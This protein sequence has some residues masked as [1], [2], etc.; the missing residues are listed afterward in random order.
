[1]N[2]EIIDM[3][4]L[5]TKKVLAV[6]LEE[7]GK[8][9]AMG[10]DGTDTSYIDKVA[11]DAILEFMD[12]ND[13]QANLLSEEAGFVDR[14]FDEVLVIDPVD[15]TYN[16]VRGIP[17]FSISIARGKKMLSDLTEGLVLNMVSGDVYH[18][19]KGKGAFLNNQPINVREPENGIVLMAYM[20]SSASPRTYELAARFRRVRALGAASLDL[21]AVAAGMADAYYLEYLPPERSLRIMDIAAGVL[22]LREAGGEA[23]TPNTPKGE[24][25]DMPLS[26]D[27]RKNIMAVGSD[28]VLEVFE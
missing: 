24:I 4:R 20:G 3:A 9:V 13:V 12:Q 14:G 22:I 1:M 28:K 19:E 27:V 16:A 15:G 26:L 23:Y 10:A 11:E 25:L 8:K 7:R 17:F 6:P 18:A 2:S 5:V 21:C